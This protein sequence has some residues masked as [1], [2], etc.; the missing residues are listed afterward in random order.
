MQDTT[1]VRDLITIPDTTHFVDTTYY[2]DTTFIVDTTIVTDTTSFID[3][4]QVTLFRYFDENSFGFLS[5]SSAESFWGMI[6]AAAAIITVALTFRSFSANRRS[7]R[8]ILLPVENPGHCQLT[9]FN[10]V[11]SEIEPAMQINL[12]NYGQ[13]PAVNTRNKFTFYDNESLLFGFSMAAPNPIPPGG[14]LIL[15]Q[16][17]EALDAAGGGMA[18]MESARYLVLKLKYKDQVIG[19]TYTETLRWNMVEGELRE[20]SASEQT[21]M[22]KLGLRRISRL[23]SSLSKE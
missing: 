19:K 8:A 21:S 18:V 7:R 15:K 9:D 13:N 12:K 10:P 22:N 3:T 20:L 23:M 4:I 14:K 6:I 17:R 11:T 16:N 1:V 5:E 2:V